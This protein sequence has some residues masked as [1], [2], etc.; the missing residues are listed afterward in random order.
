M[1]FKF[2]S[3]VFVFFTVII[4]TSCGGG[5]S[6]ENG[7]DPFGSGVTDEP[8]FKIGYFNSQNQFVE[9]EIGITRSA[10]GI[11]E[12]SA[13]GSIG[14]QVVVVNASNERVQAATLVTFT[15]SCVTAAQATITS[16]VSTVNGEADN[17][18][19]DQ[20]C[21]GASGTSDEVTATIDTSAGTASATAKIDIQPDAIGGLRFISATPLNIFLKGAGVISQTQTLVTFIVTNEQGVALADQ[22]VNFS[23]T[24]QIGGLQ[25]SKEQVISNIDGEASTQVLAGNVPTSVRVNATVSG[26]NGES[27]ITQSESIAVTTGLPSQQ[28]FSLATDLFN[29][30]GASRDGEIANFTARLS[31]TFGNPVPDNTIVNFTA[32]GGQIE[33]SCLTLAGAC[34]VAWTSANPRVN[35]GVVTVLATAIGHETLFDSNGNNIYDQD[36]GGA[37]EDNSDSGRFVS[38]FDGVTGFVD[39]SEAWR[40]DNEDGQWSSGEIF[41]DY[42]NNEQFDEAD[43]LF[44]GFQCGASELCG[45]GNAS[46]IHVRKENRLIVSSS[47]AFIDVVDVSDVRRASN[48]QDFTAG[49]VTL[50]R[51]QKTEFVV[52]VSDSSGNIM[53]ANSFINI[54]ATT[55]QLEITSG[56]IVPNVFSKQATKFTFTLENDL[57]TEDDAAVSR[58]NVLVTAPS[59]RETTLDLQVEIL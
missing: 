29:V 25:L 38:Q 50:A 27:I 39:I 57:E 36:D 59:G 43:G 51:G 42:N 28:S 2:V 17:T 16:E 32:E 6:G 49:N 44:N 3:W 54:S 46:S 53:P 4:F 18:F 21:G 1:P 31:D 24:T 12:I 7:S 45:Q 37:I 14:L 26:A 58:I 34:S 56:T 15:S 8:V 9:E 52:L 35:D 19:V 41:L 13:G 48:H 11:S 5:A 47:T 22:T 55:G 10:N 23:L 30:E 33:S 40:D 20:G